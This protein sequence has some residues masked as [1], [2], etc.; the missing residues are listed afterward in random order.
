[1]Y[2]RDVPQRLG[3]SSDQTQL[4]A[5]LTALH[6]HLAFA[7]VFITSVTAYGLLAQRVFSLLHKRERE[8]VCVYVCSSPSQCT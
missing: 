7:A 2:L 6:M 8:R 1:M 3:T 4:H 5:L